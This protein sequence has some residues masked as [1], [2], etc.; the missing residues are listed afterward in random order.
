MHRT[1]DDSPAS[2]TPPAQPAE[3]GGEARPATALLPATGEATGAGGPAGGDTP[4][5]PGRGRRRDRG[6]RRWRVPRRL[7]GMPVIFWLLHPSDNNRIAYAEFME[8]VEGQHFRRVTLVDND[9]LVGEVNEP[10]AIR[11]TVRG[12][13]RA[14]KLTTLVP[15]DMPSGR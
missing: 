2:P 11:D 4:A 15:V 10:D 7:A 5:A 9:Q 14:G 13:I 8:L 1:A 3:G 6:L 12:R